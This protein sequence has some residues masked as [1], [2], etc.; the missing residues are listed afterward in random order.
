[1]M[2]FIE[3]MN[4]YVSEINTDAVEIPQEINDVKKEGEDTLSDSTETAPTL[5]EMVDTGEIHKS[6]TE[7][8]TSTWCGC[9]NACFHSCFNVG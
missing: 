7:V 6:W 4:G 5:K 9:N 1:M 2:N 3:K 8:N